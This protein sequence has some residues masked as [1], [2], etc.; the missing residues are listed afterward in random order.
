MRVQSPE[1]CG[2]NARK[3]TMGIVRAALALAAIGLVGGVGIPRSAAQETAPDVAY[4]EAVSGRV[5]ALSRGTP[6]LLDN[7]D[8]ISDRTRLDLQ[9]NSDVSI[10]H[11]RTQRMLALKGPTRAVISADGATADSG[12]A[13]GASTGTCVAPVIS[14]FQGGLVARSAALKTTNVAL[15]P[16]IKVVNRGTVPINKIALWDSEQ[17]TI[18]GTFGRQEAHPTFE[19]GQSYVLV[20]ERNDGSELKMLLKGSATTRTGPLI[21]IV[22]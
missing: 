3:S 5:I 12:K 20:V 21:L 11:Y 2:S 7:L 8:I 1:Y 13:I 17:Q 18:L 15:Q 19:D 14:N 22:Q 10:C 16:S 4:V 6:V 9:A